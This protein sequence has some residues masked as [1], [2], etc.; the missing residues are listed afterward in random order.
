MLEEYA[1]FEMKAT[2]AIATD[3]Y[4]NMRDTDAFSNSLKEQ[5]CAGSSVVIGSWLKYY[6]L[7][8]MNADFIYI[9]SF[10]RIPEI[11]LNNLENKK[12]K[13]FFNPIYDMYSFEAVKKQWDKVFDKVLGERANKDEG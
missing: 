1:T 10:D 8:Q 12:E 13:Q 2:E 6:E 3:L 4:F 9:D 7:E 5:V 11:I